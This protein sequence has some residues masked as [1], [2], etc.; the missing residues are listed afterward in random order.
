MLEDSIVQAKI[1]SA[2][3][4]ASELGYEFEV[5][6]EMDLFGHVYNKKNMNLFIEKIR[7][8]EV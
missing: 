8:G 5:W 1:E 7:N 6:T 3:I 2:K 4:K